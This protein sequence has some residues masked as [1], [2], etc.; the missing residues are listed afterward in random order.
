M[1]TRQ[2]R[3]SFHSATDDDER[4]GE[5]DDYADV[6]PQSLHDQTT[7]DVLKTAQD[8]VALVWID[9]DLHHSL[10]Y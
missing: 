1:S 5:N 7:T 2:S 8:L 9:L 3:K 10:F 6:D 4:P